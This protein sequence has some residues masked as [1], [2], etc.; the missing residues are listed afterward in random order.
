LHKRIVII[1]ANAAGVDAA[2]AARKKDRESKITLI[3]KDEVGAYSRCGLPY[4][5]GG[6]IP[7]FED[8]IVYSSKFYNMMKL[9]LRK[10]TV[11]TQ[12]DINS[13][14]IE[15]ETKE[16]KTEN[17]EFDSLILATGSKPF[18]LPIE[19]IKK[20]GVYTLHTIEDGK[21]IVESMKNFR[22]AVVVG[23]GLVGLETAEAFTENG[24]DTTVVEM[25]PSIL[26]RLLDRDISREV[27]KRFEESGVKFI[28]NK[29]AEAIIGS[30]KVKAVSVGGKEIPAD[31][32]LNAAG[33]RPNVDLAKKAGISI[34]E[35]RGIKTNM[36]MQTSVKD[37][38][39]A[40]DCAE[41]T[42]YIT[43]RPAIPLL[44]ST[45]VR[46]G[47]VAGINASGGYATFPG[48]LFSWV[49]RIFHIE[50]GAVGLT[51]FWAQRFGLDYVVGKITSKTKAAYYPGG[52]PI[53]IKIIIECESKQVIGA[54][55]VGGEEV[56][57]RINAL[58][59]AIQTHMTVYEL[60]KADTCYAP[61]VCETWEP[62]VLA[63]EIAIRRL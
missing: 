19:G 11:A 37:V 54:Q 21:K 22:S 47:K 41:T 32:V 26:P 34:G 33:V 30:T 43:H 14:K 8:L 31:I 10:N 5:L 28:L 42:H 1:G 44:G 24:I 48:T 4:V 58:S 23:S 61:S 38:F 49:S 63:A 46:E 57:Q 17:L 55:I 16:K 53:K 13:K 51:E 60:A 45:A 35:T 62:M 3:T 39:A 27:Q 9:D 12:I 59:L 2:I 29:P 7:K 20:E 36:R 40:G 52:L 56:T 25:L 18:E 6:H 15:I 50:V